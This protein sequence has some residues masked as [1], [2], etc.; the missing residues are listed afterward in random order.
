MDERAPS[1]SKTYDTK[2]ICCMSTLHFVLDAGYDSQVMRSRYSHRC[3]S[4]L[5][6]DPDKDDGRPTG[7][8]VVA[9]EETAGYVSYW[10]L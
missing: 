5:D 2:I 8:A 9:F 6:K 4:A 1:Y 7:E 10:P 3:S